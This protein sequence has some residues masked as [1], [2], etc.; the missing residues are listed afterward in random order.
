[1][2][3]STPRHVSGADAQAAP[4]AGLQECRDWKRRLRMTEGVQRLLL[5]AL[6]HPDDTIL[7]RMLLSDDGG[8]DASIAAD[9]REVHAGLES[10]ASSPD[11]RD[12]IAR[13]TSRHAGV[14]RQQNDASDVIPVGALNLAALSGV[15]SKVYL[16]SLRDQRRAVGMALNEDLLP[17]TRL[18]ILE[19]EGRLAVDFVSMNSLTR[20]RLRRGAASLADRIAGD[21][22]R[23]VS[24]KVASH[25]DDRLALEVHAD[26]SAV[27]QRRAAA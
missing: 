10:I 20:E 24:V 15:V 22:S 13:V 16:D 7:F 1:M 17:A 6:P 12:D 21:L 27:T 5:G 18:S 14:D 11:R 25:D 26:A 3:V 4:Q 9:R 8:S 19:R 23:D 2:D